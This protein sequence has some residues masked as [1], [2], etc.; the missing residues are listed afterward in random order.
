MVTGSA[1]NWY[2]GFG[3]GKR[4]IVSGIPD[5]F[6]VRLGEAGGW[7]GPRTESGDVMGD[8]E[9]VKWLSVV[10]LEE[11]GVEMLLHSLVVGALERDGAVRGVIVESKAGRGAVCAKA[12]VDATADADV[13]HSAG[14][15]T[16]CHCKRVTLVSRI[17][18][19]D[20]ERLDRFSRA[21][22]ERF[23]ALTEEAG[24]RR[25]SFPRSCV[26]F[27]DRS[28]VDVA[29][30]TYVEN[31]ARKRV[32][33]TLDFLRKNVPG[34]EEARVASTAPQLGVRETRKIVGECTVTEQDLLDSRRWE[35]TVGRCGSYV[36]DRKTYAVSGLE[37][38]VPYGCLVPKTTDGLVVAGR[39]ISATHEAI[40]SLRVVPPCMLTGQAAGAAAAQ[41]ALT[42]TAP[43]EIDVGT[44][45]AAL[46]EGG[47]YLG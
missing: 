15:E 13:A 8:I 9:L 33:R 31:E 24:L 20:R 41:A 43:R 35:D 29:D 2:V 37:Y 30:L 26:E 39:C 10:M 42:A 11:A 27:E 38:D 1:V 34:Y 12:V 4:R 16:T 6:I 21:N 45:Q 36:S 25:G 32:F 23:S 14:V 44:L 18:G 17:E 40:D 22:P 47:A 28:G 5:E 19:V 46:R 3:N 7:I